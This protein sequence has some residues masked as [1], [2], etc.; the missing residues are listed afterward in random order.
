MQSCKHFSQHN[1]PAILTV[2]HAWNL[3]AAQRDAYYA[4]YYPDQALLAVN[5]RVPGILNAIGVMV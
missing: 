5:Q 4:G 2:R 3:T 1:L